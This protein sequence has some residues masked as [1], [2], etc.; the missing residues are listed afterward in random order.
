MSWWSIFTVWFNVLLSEPALTAVLSVTVASC[1]I[2][3]IVLFGDRE[4]DRRIR[5]VTES[6]YFTLS[7]KTYYIGYDA[8]HDTLQVT[9]LATQSRKRIDIGVLKF[10]SKTASSGKEFVISAL[11][12]QL[13]DSII[14]FSESG[15]L[16]D[17]IDEVGKWCDKIVR[18][19]IRPSDLPQELDQRAG[20]PEWSH[21]VNSPQ[22]TRE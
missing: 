15:E 14:Q 12:I 9:L 6:R 1:V 21:N 22:Q 2:I 3:A 13:T 19:E 16:Q 18:V 4:L 11:R 8:D 7:L 20:V 17:I 10:F 5:D